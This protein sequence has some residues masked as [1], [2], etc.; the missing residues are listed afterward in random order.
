MQKYKCLIV[1][2]EELAQD[3]IEKY[4]SSIPL[5]ELAGKCNNAIE[6]ISFLHENNVDI[7]FL[8]INMPE[9]TGLEMLKTLNNPPKVIL[10]TAYSEFAL[11]SY[12]FGV[13]DYL[14][15]PIKLDRFIKA[16][17]RIIEQLNIKEVIEEKS[18]QKDEETKNLFIKEEYITYSIEFKDILFVEAYGNYLKIHT[19]EKTYVIR[20][21]MQNILLKLP[22]K[23]F[24]RVHKT[25]I[26][27][28]E[29]IKKI[30]GNIIHINSQE[31]PIGNTF[32]SELTKRLYN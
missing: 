12:E 20:E 21:T 3:V 17:N 29:R 28:V 4:I 25:Y 26:V 2:D 1:E 8:D 18:E 30:S 31:I 23:Y 22:D 24:I 15:K 9:I 7:M 5:L 19:S 13:T 27:A 6:A 32:K 16:V 14:L 10:T 11:E